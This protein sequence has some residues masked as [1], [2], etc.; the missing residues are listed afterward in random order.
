MPLSKPK[1]PMNAKFF[2][3]IVSVGAI[4]GLSIAVLPNAP[5]QARKGSQADYN[6][7][8]TQLLDR[9]LNNEVV[10]LA[11][12]TAFDPRDLARCVAEIDEGTEITAV[13]ALDSCREVR[14]PREL[15]SCVV[16]IA[17]LTTTDS[18]PIVLD[19]CRR[20]LL[21]E[22]YANCVTGI[23]PPSDL[24]TLDVMDSCIDA[25][26]RIRDFYPTFIQAE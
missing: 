15:S 9:G 8:T 4:A 23:T 1:N 7:C 22:R 18:L 12:G 20:S 3:T 19:S 10:A 25:T 6:A 16:D 17:G 24:A 14:R 11:C 5:A 21:P 13:T 2:Q 26:D